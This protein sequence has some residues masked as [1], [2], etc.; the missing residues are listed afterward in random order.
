MTTEVVQ[1]SEQ[2]MVTT[3]EG[4][5]M[6]ALNFELAQELFEFVP[7]AQDFLVSQVEGGIKVLGIDLRN[8]EFVPQQFVEVLGRVR[9]ECDGADVRLVLVV[10]DMNSGGGVMG[11]LRDWHDGSPGIYL[12]E[13]LQEVGELNKLT[14][15]VI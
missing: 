15:I 14:Q 8:I 1:E 7:K 4:V 2:V 11:N 13:S 9:D 5:R 12:C 10:D 3:H 6:V